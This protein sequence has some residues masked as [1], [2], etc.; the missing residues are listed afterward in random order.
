MQSRVRINEARRIVS[1]SDA[2]PARKARMLARL[3]DQE[4]EWSLEV[5]RRWNRRRWREQQREA[6]WTALLDAAGTMVA[7]L[8]R[9]L[10]SL[11]GIGRRGT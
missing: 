8:S 3:D 5:V 9:L 4:R 1:E 6:A 10:A 11:A 2:T 7:P